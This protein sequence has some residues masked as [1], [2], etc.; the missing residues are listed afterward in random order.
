MLIKRYSPFF[1]T[2][3][4]TFFVTDLLT[5]YLRHTMTIKRF[6]DF[7]KESHEECF[8]F[9]NIESDSREFWRRS[10]AK[11]RTSSG[12]VFCQIVVKLDG[13]SVTDSLELPG[14]RYDSNLLKT[15][16]MKIRPYLNNCNQSK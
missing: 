4:L 11:R 16:G 3:L 1:V 10:A 9:V 14:F 6:N 7:N 5:F 2:N 15:W 13:V 8:L 12:N